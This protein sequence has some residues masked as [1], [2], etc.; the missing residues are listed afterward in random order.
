[1]VITD[2]ENYKQLESLVAQTGNTY[3]FNSDTSVKCVATLLEI[4]KEMGLNPMKT[5][6]L[7]QGLA[8]LFNIE[9]INMPDLD[10]T[11]F[12]FTPNHVSDFDAIILGLLHP[13]IRIVAKNDWTDNAKLQPFLDAHYDLYGFDRTS[14]P[15]LHRL[16]S[17]SIRYFNEDEE[18]KHFLVFSQG[19][20]SDFNNNSLER[21][22]TIAQKISNKTKV[23]IVPMFIEQVSLHH[24]TRIVFGTPIR[25]TLKDDFRQIWLDKEIALQNSLTPPGR[26]PNLTQKHSNNNKPGD[27]FF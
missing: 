26:R 13:K 21:V 25:P 9:I 24:P 16:L 5:A 17:D 27:P 14:L 15:S 22:S 4:T 1:M 12:I 6:D 8:H 18:N 20:I 23:P 7:Q 2:S 3:A 10:D 11:R 19:T